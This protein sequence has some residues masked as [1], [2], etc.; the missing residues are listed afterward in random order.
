MTEPTL[1]QFAVS[2]CPS[3]DWLPIDDEFH[4]L[5]ALVH[6]ALASNMMGVEEVGELFSG[7][8]STHLQRHDITCSPKRGEH[9]SSIVPTN[10]HICMQ[11]TNH[12]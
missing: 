7:L 8:L 4:S 9:R 12:A 3:T 2:S 6:S 10:L 5:I 11:S 1:L